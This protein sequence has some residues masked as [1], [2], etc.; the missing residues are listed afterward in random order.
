MSLTHWLRPATIYTAKPKL[1]ELE[2]RENPVNLVFNYD[3]DTS[4][5]FS[6]PTRRA[7]AEGVATEIESR[8]TTQLAGVTPGAGNYFTLNVF[9]P[10]DPYNSAA[11]IKIANPTIANDTLTVY[12]GGRVGAGA[13]EA[14]LGGFGGWSGSGSQS[15]FNTLRFRGQSFRAPLAGAV[16]FDPNQNW[17]F[18]GTPASNQT[19][20]ATVF[21]H[22]LLHVLGFGTSQDFAK[23]I[24]GNKFTGANATAF[25]G[26][27]NPILSGSGHFAET[28][29]SDGQYSVMKPT[30]QRGTVIRISEL[31]WAALRDIGW[32]VSAA[33]AA[34]V[35]PPTTVPVSPPTAT[36]PPA[37]VPPASVPPVLPPV[38]S[39]TTNNTNINGT[40]PPASPP[41][42]VN[43][44]TINTWSTTTINGVTTTTINGVVVPPVAPPVVV[45]PVAP[46][47]VVPP[48][49]ILPVAPPVVVPPVVVPPVA[50]PV[51][52]PPVVVPPVAPPV[53]VPPVV[54][55]P[56]VVPPVVVPPVVVPPVVVPP[57]PIVV[58]PVVVAPPVIVPPPPPIPPVVVVLPPPV[59]IPPVAVIPPVSPAPTETASSDPGFCICSGCDAIRA[60]QLGAGKGLVENSVVTATNGTIQVSDV[61]TGVLIPLAVINTTGLGNAI[62]ITT[63]DV[64]G[65]GALDIIAASGPGQTTMVKVYDGKTG[66]QIRSFVAFEGT[67]TSGAF[68]SA[69]DF[70]GDG[71]ADIVVSADRGNTPRVRI[72]SGA[73]TNVVLADFNA[74]VSGFRGGVR[75]AVGDVNNDGKLD[76]IAAAGNSGGGFVNVFN[77]TTLGTGLA[78]R[79]LVA[80]FRAMGTYTGSLFVS[81]GD[82]N[83]DGFADVV[84][85]TAE[86]TPQVRILSGALL[87]RVGGTVASF[88]PIAMFG[89]PGSGLNGARVSVGDYNGDGK[90][91][92]FLGSG[93]SNPMKGWLWSL[94]TVKNFNLGTATPADGVYVG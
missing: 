44:I 51:V 61:S 75:T 78:P 32:I 11:N 7:A 47:V 6:D 5:F 20:F 57:P 9:N 64:N 39:N 36:V 23:H 90:R 59:I 49:V 87:S 58:P 30:V 54:V 79:K 28:Q 60:A 84:V 27:V 80:D 77:G 92:I 81:A 33:P 63:A 38:T 70:N 21:R 56:Q 18:T 31:D 16:S 82:I 34:T 45:P 93:A 91:D 35:V 48:V 69:G 74:F 68:V 41:T 19:D 14:A 3:Y 66:Q 86:G 1:E 42:T 12:L 67:N 25:N 83:G 94:G 22:E 10:A 76:L 24:S 4:G 26:G 62:R 73:D 2:T 55:P 37:P 52:V 72:I 17:S 15:W 71:R 88:A 85:S 89:L 13:G 8:I 53:V 29:L 50:P 43:N 46:P 65:D 40:V